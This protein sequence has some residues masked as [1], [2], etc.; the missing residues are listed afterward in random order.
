[1]KQPG[2]P[3]F[4]FG[5]VCCIHLFLDEKFQI[6]KRARYMYYTSLYISQKLILV[7]LK[8][9]CFYNLWLSEFLLLYVST[10]YDRPNCITLQSHDPPL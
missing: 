3:R 9:M 4:I 8:D 7:L 6:R 2:I 1:M 5:L 10:I